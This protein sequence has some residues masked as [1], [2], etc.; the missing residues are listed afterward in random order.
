M[1]GGTIA[2]NSEE[3]H[4]SSFTF[5]IPYIRQNQ[6]KSDSNQNEE[7]KSGI[8]QKKLSIIVAEDDEV[9][10]L[11]L[12]RILKNEFSEI[13]Y[14]STGKETIDKC[15]ENPDTDIILMD[16]KMPDIDGFSATKLIREFNKDV[17][18]IAQTAY[19]L[20]GD[21]EKALEVGCDGYIAKPIKKESLFEKIQL[22]LNKKSN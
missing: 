19:G 14:T 5:S 8:L 9:S 4:G 22:C 3:G 20:T 17:I 7:E 21:K 15:R 11:L 13:S 18:I 12:E 2:V 1:L 16:I 6:K 10:K